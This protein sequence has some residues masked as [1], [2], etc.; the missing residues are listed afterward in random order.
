MECSIEDCNKRCLARQLC[1]THYNRL[2]IHG[3]TDHPAMAKFWAKV[4]RPE[5][6]TQCWLWLPGKAVG[7][8]GKA[9]MFGKQWLA[10]R[11]AFVLTHG[12]I[13]D[14]LVVRHECDTPLCVKPQHL[15]LGTH[16]DNV[17]DKVQRGRQN[18][19]TSHWRA[20]LSCEDVLEIRRM[21]KEGMSS[22]MLAGMFG[23]GQAQIVGL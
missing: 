9:E 15:L 20:Q 23:V 11:L 3:C 5:S 2:M 4:D 8:Y 17:L 16:Y 6:H 7:P 1:K 13:P 10:H 21:R 12:T 14:E 19:G 18:R 22:K